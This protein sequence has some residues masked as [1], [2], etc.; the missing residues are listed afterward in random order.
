MTMRASK[1]EYNKEPVLYCNTC[2]SLKVISTA[3]G[4]DFC[5][6]C[7]STDIVSSSIEEWQKRY[8][9]RYGVSQ[10]KEN[11]DEK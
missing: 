2:L 10:L 7:G 8:E 1:E 3:D 9:K 11:K 4:T 6:L 5:D